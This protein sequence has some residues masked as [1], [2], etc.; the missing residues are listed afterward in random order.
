MNFRFLFRRSF[1]LSFVLIYIG[2]STSYIG[3][4][5][6][7]TATKKVTL[8]APSISPSGSKLQADKN[9]N[10]EGNRNTVVYSAFVDMMESSGKEEENYYPH[11]RKVTLIAWQ[12]SN[13]INDNVKCC[14]L[15]SAQIAVPSRA[16]KATQCCYN[17]GLI[18]ARRVECE[19]HGIYLDIQGVSLAHINTNCSNNE[20]DYV[21]PTVLSPNLKQNK[22]A[23]C[24]KYIYGRGPNSRKLVEWFEIH[25]SLG[26]D[27]FLVHFESTIQSSTKSVLQYYQMNGLA[28]VMEIN[29]PFK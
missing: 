29:A 1:L 23:I 15:N 5:F 17:M 19:I 18:R 28:E 25:R 22:W 24:I 20:Q 21:K 7:R 14:V 2:L 11:K 12:K 4:L 26:V 9:K 3:Y 10:A 13:V 6:L 8:Q 27:K 16:I